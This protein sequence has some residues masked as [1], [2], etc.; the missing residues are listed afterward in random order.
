MH[1]G[2]LIN[3]EYVCSCHFVQYIL[4]LY[5]ISLFFSQPVYLSIPV[6]GYYGI[7]YWAGKVF[8]HIKNLVI[9]KIFYN[10]WE[11]WW[12]GTYI[13][14]W[15]LLW[16]CLKFWHH[17]SGHNCLKNV[18]FCFCLSGW[19]FFY[20]YSNLNS[21]ALKCSVSGLSFNTICTV[22]LCTVPL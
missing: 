22:P 3:R 8:M 18:Y 4:E 12:E 10:R 11:F 16:S 6:V 17:A 14:L 7:R 5:I 15:I 2:A 13:K 21:Y 1:N 9:I 20:G 19:L